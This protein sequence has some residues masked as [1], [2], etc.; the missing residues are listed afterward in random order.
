MT[1][2]VIELSACLED[3]C[4]TNPITNHKTHTRVTLHHITVG[5]YVRA[6]THACRPH[7]VCEHAHTLLW[8]ATQ[9]T[10]YYR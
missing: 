7:A 2:T 3:D 8:M 5:S 9:V 4:D 10:N 1:V 6:H